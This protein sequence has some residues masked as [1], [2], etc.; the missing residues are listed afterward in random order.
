MT[1]SES[2][3]VLRGSISL[4]SIR[5]PCVQVRPQGR[6]RWRAIHSQIDASVFNGLR[7]VF[8]LRHSTCSSLA[9][10]DPLALSLQ[11]LHRRKS[12]RHQQL[13]HVRLRRYLPRPHMYLLRSLLS[14]FTALTCVSHTM[15]S[16]WH[17]NSAVHRPA[18]QWENDVHFFIHTQRLPQTRT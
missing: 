4:L 17:Q 13:K 9:S 7:F 11:R 15:H 16:D 1:V 3:C 6:N 12:G 5:V 14:S 8:T 18:R 2:C 10:A